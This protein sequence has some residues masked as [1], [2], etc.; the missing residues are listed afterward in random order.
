MS[1]RTSSACEPP[2]APTE[3]NLRNQ[4]TPLYK[5]RDYD[6]INSGGATDIAKFYNRQFASEDTS[7][8]SPV[9][10]IS[11]QKGSNWRSKFHRA[12]N[13]ATSG[14]RSSL[15]VI[16]S[17]K[18]RKSKSSISDYSKHSHLSRS[19]RKTKRS[20][21]KGKRNLTATN[22]QFLVIDASKS[23]VPISQSFFD[24][25]ISPCSYYQ[26]VRGTKPQHMANRSRT[27]LDRQ[28]SFSAE[29]VGDNHRNA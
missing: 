21:S 19:R 18:S 15:S 20:R 1:M 27:Y 26:R 13:S 25:V 23:S 17:Q 7:Q 22:D 14:D 11:Y 4:E 12:Q 10:Q 6:H 3:I 9:N 29:H 5:L 16:K 8:K 2:I 28:Q 24:N